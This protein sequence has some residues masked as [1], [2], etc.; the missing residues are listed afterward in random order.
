MEFL[1]R[2]KS[3]NL[4]SA[5]IMPI[6]NP[7]PVS[8]RAE[9]AKAAKILQEFTMPNATKGPDSL[10]PKAVLT[11]C[12]GLAILSVFKLGFLVTARGGSGVVIA[13]LP[14]GSWSAPSAISLGGIGG[15]FEV[16]IEITDFVLVLNTSSA[17][18]SFK[19]GS[20]V[21][22]GGNLTVALGPMGRNLEADVSLRNAA[23]FFTYSKSRGLFAGIS[24][25]GSCI[26]ERK[27]AN[28]KLYGGEVRARDLLV[29]AYP[30]PAEATALYT[31]VGEASG[32]SLMDSNERRFSSARSIG[33]AAGSSSAAPASS[34]HG[35]GG[36]GA[37]TP[38]QPRP[39]FSSSGASKAKAA[40]A[41]AAK[42]QAPTDSHTPSA[43]S[44]SEF[45]HTSAVFDA[46]QIGGYT[47]MG[48]TAYTE[49]SSP[50]K[51]SV[52]AY[53]VNTVDWSAETK[54]KALYAFAG[55]RDCDLVFDEGSVI[56][57]LT[58][59]G[60]QDDWWEGR[61]AGRVGLFPANYVALL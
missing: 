22:L 14:D 38:R 53:N 4:K 61:V 58:R 37:A 26:G 21:T 31:A 54:C 2:N 50:K 51:P 3:A 28:R 44:S 10:I 39:S 42:S 48:R 8:L 7:L 12:K 34:W 55:E 18:D 60:S 56:T 19:K 13:R 17:V 49:P 43:L 36:G 15:G 23:S 29:G 32:E 47:S 40:S 27:S 33:R 6:H 24:L 20:N 52:A 35:G 11:N 1:V 30:P 41:P 57:V 45:G 5:H 25:E 59:T 9:C 46:R 16:G